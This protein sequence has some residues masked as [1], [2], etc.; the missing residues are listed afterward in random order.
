MDLNEIQ[1][2]KPDEKPESA[3]GL[4]LSVK[5]LKFMSFGQT[6]GGDLDMMT[7]QVTNFLTE[8]AEV[9]D[10]R[11]KEEREAERIEANPQ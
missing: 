11:K 1:E 2:Q 4:S 10:Q 6:L 7:D 5:M 8:T 3:A 9:M